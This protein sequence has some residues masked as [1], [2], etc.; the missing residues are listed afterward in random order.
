VVYC[1]DDLAAVDAFEVDACN[2]Q[3]RVPKLPLDDD[4]WYALASDLD[5]MRVAELVRSEAGADAGG[6]GEMAQG[7]PCRSCR[8][9]SPA[10]RASSTQ[11]HAP[12]GVVTRTS[13]TSVK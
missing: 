2:A 10:G 7:L 11:G 1:V 6:H 3:I 8:P 5:G 13:R 12:T 9:G 4:P